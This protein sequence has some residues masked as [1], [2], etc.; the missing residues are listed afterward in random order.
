VARARAGDFPVTPGNCRYCDHV[1][2]CRVG[3]YYE[4]LD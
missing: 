2:A 3:P 4:E 1:S